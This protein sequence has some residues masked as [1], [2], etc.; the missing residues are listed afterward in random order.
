MSAGIRQETAKIYRLHI[1]GG[2][3]P[4]GKAFDFIPGNRDTRKY[5][6]VFQIVNKGTGTVYYDV[7]PIIDTASNNFSGLVTAASTGK[8]VIPAG[9]SQLY[10]YSDT[11][12]DIIVNT[13]WA[14]VLSANELDGTN[15]V[16]VTNIVTNQNTIFTPIIS[17]LVPVIYNV[18][19]TT[20]DTEYSQA[21]PAGT[22]KFALS[23]IGGA[24]ADNFRLAYAAGKVATPTAPYL[25]AAQSQG[26]E[27]PEVN[28]TGV[29]VYFAASTSGGIMQIE[30]WV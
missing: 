7:D 25:Q 16:I 26:Y 21:L 15:Q 22:K 12:V 11:T 14:E 5:P 10:F 4:V 9:V 24:A 8:T 3:A 30:C 28:L 23:I 17:S 6:N 29:T 19:M 18:D 27:S 2:A 13:Y 20:A 1:I